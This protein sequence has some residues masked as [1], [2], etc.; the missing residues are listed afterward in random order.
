MFSPGPSCCDL[1][2]L[3]GGGPS[4]SYRRVLLSSLPASESLLPPLEVS[5][6]VFFFVIDFISLPPGSLSNYSLSLP[7]IGMFFDIK[8]LLEDISN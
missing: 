7:K 2:P 5:I 1:G 6:E 8:E 3:S 4:S